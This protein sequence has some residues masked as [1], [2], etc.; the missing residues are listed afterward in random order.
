MSVD[1]IKNKIN[2][3]IAKLAH[4]A[5]EDP[6][7]VKVISCL[8][9]LRTS[10][11]N[12]D[13]RLLKDSRS[14]WEK[15]RK[16]EAIL[17]LLESRIRAPTYIDD[18]IA[19]HPELKYPMKIPS[20]LFESEKVRKVIIIAP[21]A[22]EQPFRD[23]V[24]VDEM[25]RLLFPGLL[26]FRYG[27]LHKVP[28]GRWS[29]L[30][31]RVSPNIQVSDHFLVERSQLPPDYPSINPKEKVFVPI[32]VN[33]KDVGEYVRREEDVMD[34]EMLESDSTLYLQFCTKCGAVYDGDETCSCGERYL[35]FS[36]PPKS[37]PLVWNIVRMENEKELPADPVFKKFFESV[38]FS[39]DTNI[40]KILYG[41]ERRHKGLTWRI[42]YD[43]L[44]GDS[45]KT[46]GVHF[47]VSKKLCEEVCEKIKKNYPLL[48]R[49]LRILEWIWRLYDCA[50][51]K[52]GLTF[53]QALAII[54]ASLIG[55]FFRY[56][57]IP[58][59]FEDIDKVFSTI[60]NEVKLLMDGLGY[61]G[62][63]SEITMPLTE[64]ELERI[65]NDCIK[66]ILERIAK[67]ETALSFIYEVLTHS[68]KHYLLISAMIL[69]GA[70]DKDIRGHYQRGTRDIYLY[71]NLPDGNGC[72][73]TL[74]KMIKIPLKER[75]QALRDAIEKDVA[76]TLPSKDFYTILEE[77][78]SGCKAEHAD[79]IYLKLLTDP[80][81]M[82]LVEQSAI[83]DEIRQNILKDL[84]QKF[85][86]DDYS[87]SHIDALLRYVSHCKVL[88]YVKSEELFI[89]R[90]VPEMLIIR[91]N[92]NEKRE[93]SP[94]S[95]SQNLDK[96][97][98]AKVQDALE[99]C[100]DGCPMCL[101]VI[102]CEMSAFLSKYMLSR[103]L[104]EVA[105]KMIRD[106]VLIDVSR[107]TPEKVL[108][109]ALKILES[110]EVLYL[111]ASP[112]DFQNL[113]KISYSLLGQPIGKRKIH[114]CSILFD[115]REGFIIKMEVS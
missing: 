66:T 74:S 27:R 23:E 92:E 3:V 35:V 36:A 104:V 55:Y 62:S 70:D 18:Y 64:E 9:Q 79:S 53:L 59:T 45:F 106:S 98:L 46:D 19:A 69:L 56:R 49:D 5:I 6:N 83:S 58:R 87:I 2:E 20:K 33:L 72:C 21:R 43:T 85:S 78:I 24:S 22:G 108:N 101:H 84:Q 67:P 51:Q 100:L 61:I 75:I 14:E 114:I 1:E 96:D 40:S 50:N 68:I 10:I 99:M 97:V 111:K 41:F 102:F 28:V 110:E 26:T 44:Y 88:K 103:R 31:Y 105:Y 52:Y 113:L 91:L 34:A 25:M 13:I 4:K 65:A 47:K 8:A 81:T 11:E 7:L 71:D 17:G 38:A 42:F 32:E 89:F 115:W 73:L 39:P 76:V 15:I 60:A 54:K 57:E 95:A 93:I 107:A 12:I 63:I 90:I 48:A 30:R 77:L 112:P 37:Y 80:K 29:P 82:R 16:I 94:E 86:L 109:D